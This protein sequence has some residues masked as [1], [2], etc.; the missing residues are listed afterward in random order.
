MVVAAKP[1]H[2]SEL[3][4]NFEGSAEYSAWS[5]QPNVFQRARELGVNTAL[6]GWYHPYKR[7]IGHALNQCAVYDADS[8]SLPI[9]MLLNLHR[10]LE[11]TFLRERIMP[12][13]GLLAKWSRQRHIEAYVDCLEEAKRLATNPDLGFV[14]I[15]LP[16]P[17]PPGI[18]NRET[19]E[20]EVER[21]SS[22]FDN[23]ALAD[24]TLGEIR[25]AM[26]AAGLWD[27]S[28]VLASSDHW[29]RPA[30]WQSLHVWTDE[31]NR[32]ALPKGELDYR[33]PFFLKMPGQSTRIA[34]DNRFNTIIS[35]GLLIEILRGKVGDANAAKRWIDQ[36]GS[37]AQSPY[38]WDQSR[39]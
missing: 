6:V 38:M 27:G 22:Y 9:S 4:L 17:H 30:I 14:L 3:M 11:R 35:Q 39:N 12:L 25:N 18:Y 5:T 29:W 16:V 28:V 33:V 10:A 13:A 1:I 34:Y 23:L 32:F 26:E 8:V 37:A 21:E 19:G 24:R 7:V 36:N 15:H 20:F 31:D 2:S